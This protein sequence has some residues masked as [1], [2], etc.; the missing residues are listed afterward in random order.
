MSEEII[1]KCIFWI[2]PIATLNHSP[3]PSCVCCAPWGTEGVSSCSL[4]LLCCG[5]WKRYASFSFRL[6]PLTHEALHV[7]QQD[8]PFTCCHHQHLK[9]LR[10]GVASSKD[11]LLQEEQQIP[12]PI[13]PGR[14]RGVQISWRAVHPKSDPSSLPVNTRVSGESP[15]VPVLLGLEGFDLQ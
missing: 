2:R 9:L 6:V 5:V 1:S 11:V 10:L 4:Y 3:V 14:G 13:I 15:L 12:L 8:L 7:N